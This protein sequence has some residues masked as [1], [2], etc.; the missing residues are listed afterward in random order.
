MTQLK[1]II[2]GEA[3]IRFAGY[4]CGRATNLWPPFF[5]I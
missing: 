3:S 5:L 1:K 4:E 2:A